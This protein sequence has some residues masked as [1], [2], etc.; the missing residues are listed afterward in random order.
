MKSLGEVCCCCEQSVHILHF[1][2]H[3]HPTVKLARSSAGKEIPVAVLFQNLATVI[4]RTCFL[5]NPK[6]IGGQFITIYFCPMV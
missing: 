5:I 4:V 3:S 2:N 1:R 6:L